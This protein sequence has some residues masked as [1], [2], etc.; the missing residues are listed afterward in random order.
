MTTNKKEENFRKLAATIQDTSSEKK[1][2]KRKMISRA[3]AD[4]IW[5]QKS[6]SLVKNRLDAKIT[7]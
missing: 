1:I 6:V 4:L 3:A 7:E 2:E 5:Q